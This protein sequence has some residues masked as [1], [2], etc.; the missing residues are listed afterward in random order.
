M[1]IRDSTLTLMITVTVTFTLTAEAHVRGLEQHLKDLDQR[2]FELGVK[3]QVEAHDLEGL[4]ERVRADK[5]RQQALEAGAATT[6]AKALSRESPSSN[7]PTNPSTGST[8]SVTK[9]QQR[10]ELKE[11]EAKLVATLAR[12][13][14]KAKPEKKN[15]ADGEK[16]EKTFAVETRGGEEAP[17][18]LGKTQHR[19]MKGTQ[20]LGC[21]ETI[22]IE[23]FGNTLKGWPRQFSSGGFGWYTGGKIPIELKGKK[24]W[25]Q[26]GL[27]VTIPGSK[28]WL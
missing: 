24:V 23:L 7:L 16:K 22:E 8:P 20:F 2:K 6:A 17:R 1:C 19:A 14:Q 28:E 4:T 13:I 21:G 26:V 11:T 25:A 12:F 15:G 18:N 3:Q 9:L 5:A 27:N 10:R